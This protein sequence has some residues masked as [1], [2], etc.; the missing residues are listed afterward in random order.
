MRIKKTRV[1][2]NPTLLLKKGEF[3]MNKGIKIYL[4]VCFTITTILQIAIFI[5]V[6]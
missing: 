3:F 5:K 6:V 2:V 1:G 4:A